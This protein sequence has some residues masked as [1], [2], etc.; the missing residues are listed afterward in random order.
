V[1]SDTERVGGALTFGAGAGNVAST[2]GNAPL[3]AAGNAPT[4][5]SQYE[6]A[7]AD[8]TRDRQRT[9]L[10][11]RRC[12]G[13]GTTTVYERLSSNTTAHFA[14]YTVRMTAVTERPDGSLSRFR[15]VATAPIYSVVV[16]P[17]KT[18]PTDLAVT[19]YDDEQ[20][21]GHISL[22]ADADGIDVVEFRACFDRRY[23]PSTP[24]A[25]ATPDGAPATPTPTPVDTTPAPPVPTPPTTTPTP[26]QRPTATTEHMT[27]ATPTAGPGNGSAATNRR[28]GGST[29]GS[30]GDAARVS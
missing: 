10:T 27:T 7:D 18:D 15:Y 14:G 25:T 30:E 4:R 12:G 29:G 17:N 8:R 6:R 21:T 26:G 9:R 24:S 19:T 23:E 11:G 22:P 2:A 13:D 1:F 20:W 3:V 28:R 5:G 16:I